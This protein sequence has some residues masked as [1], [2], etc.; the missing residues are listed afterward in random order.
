M[1]SGRNVRAPA[2]RRYGLPDADQTATCLWLVRVGTRREAPLAG[3]RR[4]KERAASLRAEQRL[5]AGGAQRSPD[6]YE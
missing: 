6:P 2:F 3:G 4:G 5:A 1:A